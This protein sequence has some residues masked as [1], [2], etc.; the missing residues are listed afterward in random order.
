MIGV[1]CVALLALTSPGV[2]S[3]AGCDHSAF[4]TLL[5]RF[6][7]DADTTGWTRAEP[8][9]HFALNCASNGCPPLDSAL[10]AAAGSVPAYVARDA[11]PARFGG[12]DLAQV[13]RATRGYD[14]NLNQRAPRT[15]RP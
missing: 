10:V 8:R 5:V 4:D 14:W 11:T 3:V 12:V 15:R 1:A 6:V 9:I 7:H 13:H 2:G